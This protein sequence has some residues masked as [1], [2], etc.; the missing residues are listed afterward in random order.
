MDNNNKSKKDQLQAVRFAASIAIVIACLE[1][2]AVLSI[3]KQWHMWV[4]LTLNLLLIAILFTSTNPPPKSDSGQD[5]DGN[6]KSRS[7]ETS[8]AVAENN[9]REDNVLENVVNGEDVRFEEEEEEDGGGG[10][11]GGDGKLSSP[12]VLSNEELNEKV[13]AFISRFRQEYLVSD[14][15]IVRSRS[16]SD[17]VCGN[18]S[19]SKTTTHVV[20]V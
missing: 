19:F 9:R 1:R 2:A 13:E 15:K 4:F 7:P 3:F 10:G 17:D 18:G 6:T 11:G 12:A 20:R 8:P 16:S 14:V 5:S